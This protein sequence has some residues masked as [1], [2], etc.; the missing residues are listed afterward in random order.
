VIQ[1][2]ADIVWQ[3]FSSYGFIERIVVINKSGTCPNT[4]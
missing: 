3:I 2:T 4:H 1:I